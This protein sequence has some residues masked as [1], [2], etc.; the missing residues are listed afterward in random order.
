M[1]TDKSP[2]KPRGRPAV[3]PEDKLELLNLRVTASQREKIKAAGLP[4]LRA[5]IDRWKPKL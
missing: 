4:A 2:K 5:L 1:N 3:A